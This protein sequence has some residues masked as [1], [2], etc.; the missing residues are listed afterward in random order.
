MAVPL[1]FEKATVYFE[2]II[3]QIKHIHKCN[4]EKNSAKKKK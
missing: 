4:S 2:E 1:F 3:Y